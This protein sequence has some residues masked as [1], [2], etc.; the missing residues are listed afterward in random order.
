MKRLRPIACALVALF[1][2][3]AVTGC[4]D[5]IEVESLGFVIAAGLD[6]SDSPT[7][8]RGW[9]LIDM[10]VRIASGDFA[11]GGNSSDSNLVQGSGLVL[12]GTGFSP[13]DALNS[14]QDTV[15][16]QVYVAHNRVVVVA[17]ELAK[18]DMRQMLDLFHRPRQTRREAILVVARD[19][20]AKD[21]ISATF[22]LAGSSGEGLFDLI[23]L[24]SRTRGSDI[25]TVHDFLV[26]ASLEG[27]DP[28]LGVIRPAPADAEKAAAVPSRVLYSGIALFQGD[29]LVGYLDER[30]TRGLL[31]ALGRMASTNVELPCPTDPIDPILIEVQ[32]SKGNVKIELEPELHG[33]IEIVME[34][35]VIEVGCT[36]GFERTSS[37]L[38]EVHDVAVEQI[39]TEISAAITKAQE[40]MSDPFGFGAALLRRSPSVW[41]EVGTHWYEEIWPTMRV[42]IN[43]KFDIRRPGLVGG[44]YTVDR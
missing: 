34:G 38:D 6:P 40:V 15:P 7:N 10:T 23:R 21:A 31:W 28:Y 30:E 3:M 39:K 17:E 8:A 14:I 26:A 35:R 4:W 1:L 13:L 29:R 27:M 36:S 22:P 20:S 25:R 42:D 16:R 37:A 12:T 44:P 32:R 24:S 9:S 43:V 2:A 41:R 19:I 33:V 11:G 18:T 5:R